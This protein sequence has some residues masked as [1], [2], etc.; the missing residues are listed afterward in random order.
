M[1]SNKYL[2]KYTEFN[3]VVL[4]NFSICCYQY[5]NGLRQYAKPRSVLC[6]RQKIIWGSGKQHGEA[7]KFQTK[8]VMHVRKLPQK[9]INFFGLHIINHFCKTNQPIKPKTKPATKLHNLS[10]KK[11]TFF[12]NRRS[13]QFCSCS[14]HHLPATQP[15]SSNCRHTKLLHVLLKHFWPWCLPGPPLSLTSLSHVIWSKKETTCRQST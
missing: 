1:F 8:R 12:Q 10:S 4:R 9:N 7:T 13:C 6:S 14:L 11:P 5:N 3:P 2:G 15:I